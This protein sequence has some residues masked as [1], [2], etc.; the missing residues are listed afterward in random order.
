MPPVT[1]ELTPRHPDISASLIARQPLAPDTAQHVPNFCILRSYSHAVRFIAPLLGGAENRTTRVLPN[2]DNS[3]AYDI[4][5]PRSCPSP[6]H[7]L[8]SYQAEAL[9]VCPGVDARRV[10][11]LRLNRVIW[12]YARQ[13]CSS[14]RGIPAWRGGGGSHLESPTGGPRETGSSA[15]RRRRAKIVRGRL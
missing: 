11:S 9:T 12:P 7:K 5:L 1:P 13:D 14:G 4:A 8:L 6:L 10:F 15:V 2:P 3:S